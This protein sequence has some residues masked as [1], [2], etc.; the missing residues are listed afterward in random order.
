MGDRCYLSIVFRDEDEALVDN[1]LSTPDENYDNDEIPG[2]SVWVWFEANYAYTDDRG[3]LAALG[4][5]FE[6]H[7]GE[8]G[9]YG[10]CAFAAADGCLRE[11]DTDHH[12]TPV[13]PLHA[14]AAAAGVVPVPAH[15]AEY[16][17]TLRR[18]R[19]ELATPG[20]T[21]GAAALELAE[22]LGYEFREP[23]RGAHAIDACLKLL[24]AGFDS[25]TL[26]YAPL[27]HPD[28]DPAVER[29][30]YAARQGYAFR[31]RHAEEEARA[32][33]EALARAEAALNRAQGVV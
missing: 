32:A 33:K 6:G 21:G 24:C 7:H 23:W 29:W 15:A 31:L 5:P 26:N 27:P 25:P 12:G 28:D 8:G 1:Y 13:I 10:A 19:E 18:A 3:T 20:C 14:D 22:W 9:E 17:T 2:T 11:I 30:V 4:V 16:F